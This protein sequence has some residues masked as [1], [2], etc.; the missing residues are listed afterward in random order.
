MK[1]QELW[2]LPLD[3]PSVSTNRNHF[4][5]HSAVKMEVTLYT[6]LQLARYFATSPK[7]T[8]AAPNVQPVT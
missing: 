6:S 3:M 8:H 2:M 7:Y 4:Y 5:T 1:K